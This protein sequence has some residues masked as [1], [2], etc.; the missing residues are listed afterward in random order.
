MNLDLDPA[1]PPSGLPLPH[2]GSS[3]HVIAPCFKKLDFGV[4]KMLEQLF[5]APL[6]WLWMS[7]IAIA[8]SSTSSCSLLVV[9]QSTSAG[10]SN[11]TLSVLDSRITYEPELEKWDMRTFVGSG[12]SVVQYVSITEFV[13]ETTADG[14]LLISPKVNMT[15]RGE[16]L[17]FLVHAFLRGVGAKLLLDDGRLST[18][19]PLAYFPV[20]HEYRSLRRQ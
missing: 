9:A 11:E 13:L 1:P 17:A 4:R 2:V 3:R 5:S 7:C 15:F 20:Q 6:V 10:G 16:C 14:T 19:L 8:M 12:E 18:P